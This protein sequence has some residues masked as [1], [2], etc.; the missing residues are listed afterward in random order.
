MIPVKQFEQWIRKQ[1]FVMLDGGKCRQLVMRH[2]TS[3]SRT[4][5]VVLKLDVPEDVDDNWVVTARDELSNTAQ[6]DSDGVGGMQSYVIHSFHGED[7]TPTARFTIRMHGEAE[8]EDDNI[9]T[10][11]PTKSGLLSQTMRH[12]EAVMRTSAIMQASALQTTQ[13]IVGQQEQIIEKLV[14]EKFDNIDTVEALLS[15]KSERE[16]EQARAAHKMDI[17]DKLVEKVNLLV[18]VIMGKIA[19]SGQ[20]MLTAGQSPLEAQ[21]GAL[22]DSFDTDQLN[23]LQKVMRPEQLMVLLDM[24]T[25]VKQKQQAAQSAPPD[26]NQK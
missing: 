10:E 22:A 4:G 14:K 23:A 5:Q 9:S 7:E 2:V 1:V 11:P 8:V 6:A 12:L 17:Q 15:Q 21:L 13:R 25:Q 20:K 26:E 16:I 19:G 18:P 3:A 24:I